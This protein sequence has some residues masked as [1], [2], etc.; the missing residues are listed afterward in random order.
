MARAAPAYSCPL[1]DS[2]ISRQVYERVLRIDEARKKETADRVS[3][4]RSA[5]EQPLLRK[6][7]KLRED[8]KTSEERRRR[9]VDGLNRAI[10]DLKQKADAHEHSHFGPEGEKQLFEALKGA[11]SGDGVEHR[12][13]G[14]DVIHT[15]VDRA[16]SFM[17]AREPPHGR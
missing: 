12:G 10:S 13:K 6:T 5:A 9:E 7:E 8:L 15:V 14:G 3:E 1:S 17:S 11:F 16:K 4:A 2:A